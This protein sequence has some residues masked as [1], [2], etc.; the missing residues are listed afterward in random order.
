MGQEDP[1]QKCSVE[2]RAPNTVDFFPFVFMFLTGFVTKA[3][4]IRAGC[5]LPHHS[6]DLS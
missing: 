2:L 3:D 6:D 1:E 4:N 5:S